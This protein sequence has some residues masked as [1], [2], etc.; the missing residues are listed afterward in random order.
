M[1]ERVVIRFVDLTENSRIGVSNC[2]NFDIYGFFIFSE[3]LL[4]FLP[5]NKD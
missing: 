1:N 5:S 2:R 4:E 3:A